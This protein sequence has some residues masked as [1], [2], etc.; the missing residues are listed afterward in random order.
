MVES[1]VFKVGAEERKGKI[2]VTIVESKGGVSSWV[3][4]GSASVRFFIEGL[5]QCIRDGKEG[6]W[7]RGWKEKGRSYSLV[8]EANRAGC[9]L[10]LGVI[11]MEK[12]RYSICI[13]KSKGEKG[14][15]AS[16]VESLRNVGFWFDN[17]ENNQEERA[18]GKSYVEVAK[19]LRS[20]DVTRVRVEVKVEEIRSNLSRL[21]H[22]L[23]GKWNPSSAQEEDLERLGWSVASA[24][25]LKGKLGLARLG[26]G[27]VLLECEFEEEAR[28]V[29]ASG[30]RSVGGLQMG[31]E[32]WSPKSG[33]STEGEARNEAWVKI[34]GIP[35]SLWVP[36]ILRRVG[37]ACGGF[38]GFE[39]QTKRMKELEWARVL[40]KTNGDE[41]S[42]S[43]EIG[44][45]GETYALSLWWEISSSLRKK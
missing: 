44:V 17:K 45:E 11:N 36:T 16:M 4:L 42:S 5:V 35:I 10:R 19:G 13:P 26:K 14:G 41:L 40:I 9:F 23:V 27:R 7:E 39:S 3:R 18:T 6:R 24:W 33:C 15:W 20:R 25:G 29:L 28:N 38:L 21:E 12:I 37:E 34:L 32:R 2:Q 31:L 1:K 8:R 22:C 43:L 30:K